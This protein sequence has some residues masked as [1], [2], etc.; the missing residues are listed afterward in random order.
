MICRWVPFYTIFFVLGSQKTSIFALRKR[1][2][3]FIKIICKIPSEP[4]LTKTH[5]FVEY[6]NFITKYAEGMV[7]TW[8]FGLKLIDV[9]I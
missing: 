6:E 9:Y 7:I 8:S 2:M 3:I 1:K 5:L 4:V